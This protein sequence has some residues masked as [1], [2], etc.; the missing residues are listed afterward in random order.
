[1][2][3]LESLLSESQSSNL[4]QAQNELPAFILIFFIILSHG[5][6]VIFKKMIKHERLKSLPQKTLPSLP[7]RGK[8]SLAS[9]SLEIS[10]PS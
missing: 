1:M 7:S 9:I 3:A 6:S 2:M 5:N 10:L 8:E 4:T